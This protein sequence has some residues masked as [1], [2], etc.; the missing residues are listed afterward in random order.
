MKKYFYEFTYI[1]NPVLE[2][3]KFK[4]TTEKVNKLIEDN[5]GEIVEVDEWGI[6]SLAYEINGK[7]NGYYVNMY[8]NA[9]AAA[10]E[11]IERNVRIN[12]DIMRYLTLKYDAKMQRHY[13]LKKK[14]ELPQI[15]E[16]TEEAEEE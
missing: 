14:G 4:E 3:D 11:V 7:S 16:E 9:P 13:E 5:G 15:I 12:D 8:F 2:E 6:K 10:I 1:I